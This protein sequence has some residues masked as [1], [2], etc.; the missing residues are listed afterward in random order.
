MQKK[1]QK[2]SGFTRIRERQGTTDPYTTIDVIRNDNWADPPAAPRE[3]GPAGEH[4][5]EQIAADM[6]LEERAVILRFNADLDT[7]LRLSREDF[8]RQAGDSLERSL[9]TAEEFASGTRV[10]TVPRRHRSPSSTRTRSRALSRSPSWISRPRQRRRRQNLSE[11]EDEDMNAILQASRAGQQIQIEERCAACGNAGVH[12][13][14]QVC[15]RCGTHGA[16]AA[17]SRAA[18][19]VEAASRAG[20]MGEDMLSTLSPASFLPTPR[21]AN[22]RRRRSPS[23]T[24]SPHQPR[25]LGFLAIHWWNAGCTDPHLREVSRFRWTT[26][27]NC[28]PQ[29]ADCS[30]RHR[31]APRVTACSRH[32]YSRHWLL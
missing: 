31:G 1:T 8:V 6:A 24:S 10:I 13:I 17:V 22:H 3:P 2:H 30:R 25:D 27:R 12:R 4:L 16:L 7:A 14:L 18:R 19:V 21:P 29:I 9:S 26:A 15:E 11:E 28:Q 32:M 20:T 23:H 5:H